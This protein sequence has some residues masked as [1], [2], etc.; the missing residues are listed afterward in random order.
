MNYGPS[1]NNVTMINNLPDLVDV[2]KESYEQDP[3]L[4]KYMR[5]PHPALPESGMTPEPKQ[6]NKP[7]FNFDPGMQQPEPNAPIFGN[8]SKFEP[9]CLEVADHIAYCPIC[10]KFY[11][12]DKNR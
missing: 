10:S 1:S 12:N 4:Q 11:N 5:Q 7:D 9:T 8:F 6:P 2:E 3:K